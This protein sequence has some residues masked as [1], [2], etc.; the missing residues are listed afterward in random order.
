MSKSN[1][2]VGS[3]SAIARAAG[4]S[5]AEAF[6]GADAI[7]VVDTSGSMDQADSRG[8]RRRY[9]VAC[10][11]LGKLQ[12]LMPGRIAVVAFSDAPQ[13]AP[14]GVPP[15]T[16]G[17]TDL[18]RALA[19]VK[20][21]DGC[22]RVIVVSDGEPNA[23]GAAMREARG[24]KSPIDVVYVGPEGGSGATFLADLARA[25]GGTY[26]TADRAH[27][28]ASAVQKMIATGAVT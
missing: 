13:F 8:G 9:D 17:G 11:E 27:E 19:F 14:G 23:P 10:E 1:A 3:L 6:L 7:V 18:A 12:E 26:V 25:S 28:L 16:S 4:Q 20:P 5:L 22:V 15:F 2:I 24:F 21:A